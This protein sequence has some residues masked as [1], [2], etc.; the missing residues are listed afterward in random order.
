MGHVNAYPIFREFSC[1]A[2]MNLEAAFDAL[3]LD[4]RWTARRTNDST[5]LLDRA[6]VLI[7]TRGQRMARID[8][9]YL[10]RFRPRLDVRT[11]NVA[12]R[13]ESSTPGI[14]AYAKET[15]DRCLRTS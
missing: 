9:R 12:G 14:S 15:L 3:A 13:R 5:L 2:R 4:P 11:L 7:A 10:A 1:A 6:G 8:P